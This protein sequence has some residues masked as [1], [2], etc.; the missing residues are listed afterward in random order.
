M[1]LAVQVF[2]ARWLPLLLREAAVFRTQLP[3]LMATLAQQDRVVAGWMA[4]HLTETLIAIETILPEEDF[5]I[6][7]LEITTL[8]A[9]RLRPQAA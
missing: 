4:R 1:E 5:T 9:D 3:G 6:A 7:H 2:R 8:T